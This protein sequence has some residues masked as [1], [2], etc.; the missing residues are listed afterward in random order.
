MRRKLFNFLKQIRMIRAIKNAIFSFP[1]R[2]FR[3]RIRC[4]WRICRKIPGWK[5]V[6]D[7]EHHPQLIVSLTSFPARIHTVHHTVQSLLLQSEKP[8]KVILWL[9]S[10]QFP[11]GKKMLPHDL[12]S[13]EKH[14]L[15]IEWC[16][17]IRSYK[18][19]IPALQRYPEAVIVTTDDDLYYARNWLKRLYQEYCK[20]PNVVHCHRVTKFY[21][22]DGRYCT[23]GGIRKPIPR[24]SY[25][26]KVT[27]C[28]GVLYPPHC[29]SDD[30]FD[31]AL[32]QDICATND[33]IWFWLMAVLNGVK[34]RV[35]ARNMI[36][37]HYVE[38]TQEG[39]TLSSVNDHG[40]RLFWVQF[41]NMLEHYP[42]LDGILRKEYA[43]I[44]TTGEIML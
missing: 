42:Q 29:L 11:E 25:L 44:L 20:K 24:E 6:A 22:K 18:K 14:G 28:G 1:E 26:Y 23:V 36:K 27:G 31:E 19:L 8:D 32:F 2:F 12:T 33:D 3:F 37:I 5:G 7:Q 16:H 30:V 21:I 17:D 41:G 35:P 34:V 38:G 40:E 13:L 39:P 4:R 15:T 43:D 10:E 9:A